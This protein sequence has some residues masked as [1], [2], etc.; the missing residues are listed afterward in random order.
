MRALE[1]KNAKLEIGVSRLDAVLPTTYTK[2]YVIYCQRENEKCVWTEDQ[3]QDPASKT[4][5]GH[6]W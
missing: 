2:G 5:A 6:R 4:E 1:S 3:N